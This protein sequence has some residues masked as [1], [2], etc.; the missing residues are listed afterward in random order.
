MRVTQTSVQ[1]Q[2]GK[3]FPNP[4]ITDAIPAAQRRL[5]A[6]EAAKWRRFREHTGHDVG[7]TRPLA[8]ADVSWPSLPPGGM[9]PDRSTAAEMSHES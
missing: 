4:K 7:D 2:G 5:D 1:L 9:P 3:S 6:A 8:T